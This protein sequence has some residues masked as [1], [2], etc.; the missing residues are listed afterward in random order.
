MKKSLS[1]TLGR[2][3]FHFNFAVD[4]I[5]NLKIEKTDEAEISSVTATSDSAQPAA[6]DSSTAT[7][8]S[9]GNLET[10]S[11]KQFKATDNSFKFNFSIE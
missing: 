10:N 5:E 7:A 4:E 8:L 9:S 2:E 3:Q 1:T 11:A 6:G